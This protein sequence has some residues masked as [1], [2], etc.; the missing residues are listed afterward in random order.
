MQHQ[1]PEKNVLRYNNIAP[2]INHLKAFEATARLGSMTKAAKEINTTVSSISRHNKI[3]SDFLGINLFTQ[4]GKHSHLTNEGRILYDAVK[5]SFESLSEVTHYISDHKNQNT[6]RLIV[7]RVLMHRWMVP[8]IKVF[9]AKQPNFLI[10]VDCQED[11]SFNP[12]Y[13]S[14]SFQADTDHSEVL[15][16]DEILPVVNP[17]SLE[18]RSE[19]TIRLI[20]TAKDMTDWD[21]WF[22]RVPE[23]QTLKTSKI[24]IADENTALEAACRGIG[25]VITRRSV[26]Q[27][28]IKDGLLSPLGVSCARQSAFIWCTSPQNRNL[29]YEEKLFRTFLKSEAIRTY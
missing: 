22:H 27:D 26:A 15:C 11:H 7:P 28:A 24:F 17:A 16:P 21:D 25:A 2:I 9:L 20:C 8:K 14:I 18:M 19:S 4:Y 6:V 10:K 12:A 13:L 1:R 23:L 29:S 3:I 5:Q